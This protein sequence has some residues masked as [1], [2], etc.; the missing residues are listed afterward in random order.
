MLRALRRQR[1][2][3]KVPPYLTLTQG[4]WSLQG[5]HAVL[6]PGRSFSHLPATP[7]SPDFS[8]EPEALLSEPWHDP[9]RAQAAAAVIQSECRQEKAAL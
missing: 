7:S 4:C 9:H 5:A 1:S 8:M 2:G 3:W 6:D